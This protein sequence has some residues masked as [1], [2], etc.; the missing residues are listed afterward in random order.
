LATIPGIENSGQNHTRQKVP[1]LFSRLKLLLMGG[2]GTI[3]GALAK[4]Q[5]ELTNPEKSLTAT[6]RSPF[7]RESDRTFRA[8]ENRI[9]GVS[10]ATARRNSPPED[11]GSILSEPCLFPT[12]IV[13]PRP[14]LASR[15]SP[16]GAPQP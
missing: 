1:R 13:R 6:I 14:A 16:P 5:A 3:A 8:A 12:D 7:P 15:S 11:N 2:R 4:A 9:F 10:P